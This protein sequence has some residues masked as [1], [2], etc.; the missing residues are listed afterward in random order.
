MIAERLEANPVGGALDRDP[1]RVHD[2]E[3]GHVDVQHRPFRLRN[4]LLQG[5]GGAVDGERVRVE[6]AQVGEPPRLV[7]RRRE[8]QR[9]VALEQVGP[10]GAYLRCRI[11][12]LP[13]GSVKKAMLQTPESRSPT[14]ST[15]HPPARRARRHVGDAERDAVCGAARK[16]DAHL[17]RL[18]ERERDVAGLELGGL[19]RIL[20]QLEHV[21]VERGRPLHVASR[22]VHEVHALDLHAFLRCRTRPL[23]S[24]RRRTPSGARPCRRRRRRTRRPRLELLPRRGDI[25]HAQG[26]AVPI[27]RERDADRLRVDEQQSPRRRRSRRS[28]SS[29]R[30]SPSVSP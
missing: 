13:S 18:P 3:P 22:H 8:R 10:H 6:A 17:L 20:R 16:L 28:R 5:D 4:S 15:P 27:R 9:L 29:E 30:G 11:S 12:E 19:A 2:G 21:A 14:N 7:G 25:R 23:P 24:G 1:G 26:E